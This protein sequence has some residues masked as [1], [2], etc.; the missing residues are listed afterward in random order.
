[1]YSGI[2]RR[3]LAAGLAIPAVLMAGCQSGV[4]SGPRIVA[5]SEVSGGQQTGTVGGQL[6]LPLVIKVADQGGN[7]AAGITI[8]WRVLSGGGLVTPSQSTT[9][10]DGTASATFR[11]GNTLGEQRVEAA[12]SGAQPVTFAATANAAPAS[13]LIVSSGDNQSGTV[14]ASVPAPLVVKAADAFGNAKSGITVVFAV[15]QGGGVL[16]AGAAVTGADG[17]AS[18]A[19]T[20]GAA[21][22]NQ[23][24]TATVSGVSPLSF[25]ATANPG[26]ASKVTVLSGNNQAAPPG[27]SLTDSLRLKVTDQFDNPI[28]DVTIVWAALGD[29]GST[30][31]AVTVTNV[32]GVAATQWTLGATGGPKSVR[33]VAGSLAP[34]T[35]NAAGTVVFAQVVSGGRHSCGL[36][37]GG[38]A[39][40]WGFNGDGQ[41]GM[42]LDVGGS[43]PVFAT[44]QPMAVAGALT[45]SL[46]NGG[47][48]HTCGLTLSS[49]PY[50]WGKN[51]D[52]RL[53]AASAGTTANAP[54]HVDGG[55][56]FGSIRAGGAHTCSLTQGGRVNC[57][58]ANGEGQ[59][60]V[61]LG[62]IITSDSLT[63]GS[64]VPVMPATIFS[65]V[66]AGGLHSCALTSTGA[67][68][69]W[70]Y[71][72]SGQLGNGTSTG[73]TFPV[74]VSGGL[75]LVSITTGL[76]H[77]CGLTAAGAAWCW[78]TNANGELGDGTIL[79]R[80][81]PVL[82]SGGLTFASIAAGA[83][84]TC[85]VTPAGV[86]Y[87]WGKNSSGQLGD[88]T[89][90]SATGPV[91]VGS[92]LL[93]SALGT[94]DLH[95][96]GVTTGR[97]AYCWGNNQ[98]GQ[99]GDG[100]QTNRT[101]PRKVSFQ[102]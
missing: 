54:A 90:G 43:G 28:K 16:S 47:A 27:T 44:P 63:F 61:V 76:A 74:L 45:F 85:G 17:L 35:F 48:Y 7:P 87:C 11:L 77:S 53:G 20:L 75:T 62:G 94:G 49:N 92:G 12:L 55:Q 59:V 42:G 68:W 84:H 10:A 98:Y 88:G 41:L 89:T 93:F 51:I 66:S 39:Y 99:L 33:A 46:L 64:P 80:T 6:P 82:V 38:V 102:P 96:C 71:N 67:P 65:N 9:G 21:A 19:W 40:C 32:L 14:G 83:S 2:I 97:V 37:E 8:S 18:V 52:G 36:D 69:C 26:P 101:L 81:T 95:T 100:T 3:L 31:P 29:G 86:A 13:Q 70:G 1:M 60:G 78:G 22:G 4:I 73:S 91:A 56:V 25:N 24:V 15:T 57:W 23:R 34:A 5:L 72:T 79:L 50:C 30:S 58:G